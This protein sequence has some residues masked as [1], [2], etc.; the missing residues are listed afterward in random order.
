MTATLLSTKEAWYSKTGEKWDH[1][2]SSTGLTWPTVPQPQLMRISLGDLGEEESFSPLPANFSH[3]FPNLES[4]HLWSVADLS[5]IPGLPPGLKQLDIQKCGS[6]DSLPALPTTLDTLVLV[7]PSAKLKLERAPHGGP[8]P[9]LLHLKIQGVAKVEQEWFD[10]ILDSANSPLLQCFECT[11][12][13]DLRTIS[14][15]PSTLT[16]LDLRKCPNLESLPATLP[17][18]LRLLNLFQCGK[19]S[20]LPNFPAA[21]DYV[22]LQDTSELKHLPAN[23]GKPSSLFIHGSGLELPPELLVKGNKSADVDAFLTEM[24]IGTPGWDHEVKVILLGNGRCGKTS[25]VR[26]LQ[27]GP[28]KKDDPRDPFNKRENSTHGIKLWTHPMEFHPVDGLG[29]NEFADA[30]LNIWDFAGQDLYHNTHRLFF[31]SKAIFIL[32]YTDHEPG[33]DEE[34]D[35]EAR[36]KAT[37]EGDVPRPHSYWRNQLAHLPAPPGLEKPPLIV[38][39][40]KAERDEDPN[41]ERNP[42]FG[43]DTDDFINFSAKEG[44]GLDKLKEKLVEAIA[45]VLGKKGQ[46]RIP[47]RLLD[48]KADLQKLKG[49]NEKAFENKQESPHPFITRDVFNAKVSAI[50]P[51]SLY[52]KNP[53]LAL[54]FLHNSG[55]LHADGRFLKNEVVLD[56]RWAID[57]IYSAFNR[58]KS[59]ENLRPPKGN[60]QFTTQQIREWGWRDEVGDDLYSAESRALFLNFMQECNICFELVPAWRAPDG[61]AVYLVPQGLPDRATALSTG[62]NLGNLKPNQAAGQV[63]ESPDLHPGLIVELL[64]RLGSGWGTS[65]VLWKWGGLFESFAR[66]EHGQRR[67]PAFV[68]I[69]YTGPE[70]GNFGGQLELFPY[71]D[72]REFLDA[73]LNEWCQLPGFEERPIELPEI[74]TESR[75]EQFQGRPLETHPIEVGISFA[76]GQEQWPLRLAEKL[77]K[78]GFKVENYRIEGGRPRVDRA[79]TGR[80]YLDAVVSKDFTFVFLSHKYLCSEYCCYE[81][82]KLI[83]RLDPNNWE[84]NGGPNA[85]LVRVA[86]YPDLLIKS[87]SSDTGGG[88]YYASVWY[89]KNKKYKLLAAIRTL[90]RDRQI[91][92]SAQIASLEELLDMKG[93]LP[94]PGDLSTLNQ[95]FTPFMQELG[96]CLGLNDALKIQRQLV[97]AYDFGPWIEWEDEKGADLITALGKWRPEKVDDEQIDEPR[98]GKWI[99]ELDTFLNREDILVNYALNSFAAGKKTLAAEQ[100]RTALEV[101]HGPTWAARI[102]TEKPF[103]PDSDLY[104]IWTRVKSEIHSAS[105]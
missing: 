22:D 52:A 11:E 20:T 51:G 59:W 45:Q 17:A 29:D 39:R 58:G 5:A 74:Q 43:P 23:R 27:Y 70:D 98:I 86:A 82:M 84:I 7:S 25:L 4:L 21:L 34:T 53:G 15:L 87:G 66:D 63:I 30:T 96:Q 55:F 65:A 97:N 6:L 38:V 41:A 8:F 103:D 101:K 54:D 46:R 26:R 90:P 77:A 62:N 56:L 57:G 42:L 2:P 35:K 44:T 80:S 102:E 16:E 85:S 10:S 13:G 40:T 32:C 64:V 72:G 92:L 31:Q 47:G 9:G 83:K 76:G 68:E 49:E 99:D 104:Q 89:L 61:E 28:P 1:D 88:S 36:E 91:E 105:E 67:S 81:L 19:V 79:E 33:A 95:Q 48:L 14:H 94:T 18:S 12:V 100:Y 3:L 37:A 50:L 69:N 75:I 24:E 71:G 78:K 73:I 60:G 93:E